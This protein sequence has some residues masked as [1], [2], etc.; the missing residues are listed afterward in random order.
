VKSTVTTNTCVGY[1]VTFG[2]PFLLRGP[3]PYSC[4]ANEYDCQSVVFIWSHTW[5]L[6]LYIH[7]L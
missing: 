5:T 7:L 3:F 2:L 4:L 1:T 6:H